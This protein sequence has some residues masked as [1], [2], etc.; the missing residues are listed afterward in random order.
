MANETDTGTLLGSFFAIWADTDMV[1][2]LTPHNVTRP[3]FRNAGKVPSLVYQWGIVADEG[4]ATAA[5]SIT[6]LDEGGSGLSNFGNGVTGT[7]QAATAA[8]AGMMTTLSDEL[9]AIAPFSPTQVNI[10]LGKGMGERYETDMTALFAGL[11]NATG[12]SGVDFTIAQLLEAKIALTNRDV[13]GE[14]VAVVHTQQAGDL[15]TDLATT[16]ASLYGGQNQGGGG[17]DETGMAGYVAA[18]HGVPV[19]RTSVCAT[20]NGGADRSGA[21]FEVNNTFGIY[22]V[23]GPRIRTERDESGPGEEYVATGCYGVVEIHDDRGQ[24]IITDA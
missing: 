24:E 20:A 17:L 11:T 15:E 12:T 2:A 23:W 19:Y 21:L 22:E 6:T 9:A 4:A 3:F 13:T 18:P 10:T 5:G 7:T 1:Q 16:G 8:V 14:I